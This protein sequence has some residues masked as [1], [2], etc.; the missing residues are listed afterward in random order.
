MANPTVCLTAQKLTPR[1]PQIETTHFIKYSKKHYWTMR[2]VSA[3][4]TDMAKRRTAKLSDQV[5]RAIDE[6][7]L[8][9]YA[10]AKATG[11]DES[12]LAKF[13]HGERGLSLASLDQLGEYLCLRIVMDGKP[14][15]KGK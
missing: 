1:N 12:A 9:R 5:R 8:T 2:L 4:M 3:I 7:G 14:K 11:I 13:F 10:I 6:S 15:G